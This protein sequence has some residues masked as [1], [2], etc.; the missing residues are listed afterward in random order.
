MDARVAVVGGIRDRS[1]LG[2]DALERDRRILQRE[3]RGGVLDA[4]RAAVL[5]DLGFADDGLERTGLVGL[6]E[7]H[8]NLRS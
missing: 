7:G 8:G 2:L 4:A 6:A 3:P 5:D 1:V